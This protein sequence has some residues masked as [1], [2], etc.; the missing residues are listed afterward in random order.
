MKR[1]RMLTRAIIREYEEVC[2]KRT[3]ADRRWL[4]LLDQ[5]EAHDVNL[6]HDLDAVVGRRLAEASDS[7]VRYTVK[8][9]VEK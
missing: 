6:M 7:A 8:M 3:D 4:E 9:F 2:H 1:R 5:V